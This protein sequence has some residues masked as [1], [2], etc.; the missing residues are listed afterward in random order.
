MDPDRIL[1]G[2]AAGLTTINTE[3]ARPD[4]QIVCSLAGYAGDRRAAL[5]TQELAE[6][7]SDADFRKAQRLFPQ[8][9]VHLDQLVD[10]TF[11]LVDYEWRLIT[12]VAVALLSEKTLDAG[13]I[14][15]LIETGSC[16]ITRPSALPFRSSLDP[17]FEQQVVTELN[18][19]RGDLDLV[20]AAVRKHG[21]PHPN[22][23]QN[24]T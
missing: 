6:F 15:A 18:A 12:T 3:N 14:Q 8:A 10:E 21:W 9:S 11:Q 5:C 4:D 17:E 2:H 24:P 1:R 7:G 22:R 13:Q 19:Q 16:P 20:L 23:C